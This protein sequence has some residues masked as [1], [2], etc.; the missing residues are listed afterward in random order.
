[1][2][3]F[4]GWAH[5]VGSLLGVAAGCLALSVG[6]WPAGRFRLFSLLYLDS[7]AAPCVSRCLLLLRRALGAQAQ[8]RRWGR[9][10][11]GHV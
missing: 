9:W 4:G 2:V 6:S 10:G 11:G 1:M 3:G 5:G 8:A 7:T